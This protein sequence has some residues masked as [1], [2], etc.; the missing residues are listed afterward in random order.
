MKTSDLVKLNTGSVI[1]VTY[2]CR[3]PYNAYKM[4]WH[5]S[6]NSVV[7]V[8]DGEFIDIGNADSISAAKRCFVSWF[9]RG[10]FND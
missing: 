6:D 10:R 5:K 7:A 1:T 4:F 9:N 3:A 8:V 2:L